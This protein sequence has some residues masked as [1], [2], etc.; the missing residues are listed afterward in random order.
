MKKKESMF[1][2]KN[3]VKNTEYNINNFIRFTLDV[4]TNHINSFVM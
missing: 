1:R 4:D 3:N 2:Q